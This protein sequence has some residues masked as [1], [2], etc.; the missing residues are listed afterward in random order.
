VPSIEKQLSI[1]K[2]YKTITDRIALKQQINEKLEETARTYFQSLFAK[3]TDSSNDELPTEWRWAKVGDYCKENIANVS[4]ADASKFIVYLDIGSINK[5]YFDNF[6]VLSSSDEIPSRAKRKVFDGD[7]VY[8]TVRPN[9]KHYGIIYNPPSN[10]VVSTGFAVLHNNGKGVSNELIYLWIT[11]NS[12]AE[13]L[14]SMAENSVSTYPTLNV[15]DLLDVRISVPDN[16]TL[17]QANRFLRAVFSAISSNNLE[18]RQLIALQ[19]ILL[20][21]LL[22]MDDKVL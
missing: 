7:I 3:Y 6:Q 14:Q 12:I 19:N 2:A 18:L 9:L 1:V 16:Q 22:S 4:T 20:P 5:N 10:M 13:Y 15:S 17:E 11:S 8:S 21:K